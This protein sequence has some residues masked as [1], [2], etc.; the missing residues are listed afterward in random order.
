M[1]GSG[2]DPVLRGVSVQSQEPP[3]LDTPPSR[4]MTGSMKQGLDKKSENNPMHSRDCV[5]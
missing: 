3:V 2:D 1:T 5:P 4:G